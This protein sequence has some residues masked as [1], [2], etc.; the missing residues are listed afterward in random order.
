MI[1]LHS[2]KPPILHRDLTS[3]NILYKFDNHAK[4]PL[5]IH[6]KVCDFGLSRAKEGSV[7]TAFCGAMEWMAPEAY[8][9]EQYTEAVDVFSF[10]I[11]CWEIFTA[12][13]PAISANK[14]P[15]EYAAAVS[16]G[17]R[18]E[19]PT[20]CPLHWK[21]LIECCWDPLPSKRPTFEAILSTL[22]HFVEVMK[23]PITNSFASLKGYYY[24]EK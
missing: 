14:N 2:R 15:R 7:M 11:I 19:I 4:D 22:D 23:N 8:R 9:G 24:D 20:Q 6:C 12:R 18:L 21:E 10:A 3:R 16:S 17:Y 13:D 5:Y 1:Y